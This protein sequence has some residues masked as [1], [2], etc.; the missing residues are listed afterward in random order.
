MSYIK[1]REGRYRS[2]Q[3]GQTVNLLA[4]RL[5][6]FESSP[7]HFSQRRRLRVLP[8]A[9]V[10]LGRGFG[11][12]RLLPTRF[13]DFAAPRAGFLFA[14]LDREDFIARFGAGLKTRAV[15]FFTAGLSRPSPAAFPAIAPTIPPTTAPAGPIILPSAAPATAPAVSL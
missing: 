2:G 6:W 3:T 13:F 1:A 5:R 8:R 15:A 11:L 12:T 14:V 10:D 4:L 7:A 9:D